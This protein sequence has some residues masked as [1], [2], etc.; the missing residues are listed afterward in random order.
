MI[1]PLRSRRT[2]CCALTSFVLISAC[3]DQGGTVD[4]ARTT[5]AAPLATAGVQFDRVTTLTTRHAVERVAGLGDVNGDGYDDVGLGQSRYAPADDSFADLGRVSILFG[6]ASGIT[7]A[8]AQHVDGTVRGERR[9]RFVRAGDVNGDGY[10]DVLI[11]G[12]MDNLQDTGTA[13]HLGGP[14]GLGATP[15]W[16]LPRRPVYARAQGNVGDVNGDGRSDV[17]FQISEYVGDAWRKQLGVYAG[18]ATGL[19]PTPI[20]HV[21]VPTELPIDAAAGVGD[22][23][24]D[25][26][27]DVSLGSAFCDWARG[28]ELAVY[29]GAASG[30]STSAGWTAQV[31]TCTSATH[32]LVAAGD[33]NGDG[34]ADITSSTGGRTDIT[35]AALGFFGGASPIRQPFWNVSFPENDADGTDISGAGDTNGDGYADV[36]LGRDYHFNPSNGKDAELPPRGL[37]SVYHGASGGLPET[38]SWWAYDDTQNGGLF[39]SSTAGAGD[40]N[41]D[42][43]ADLVVSDPVVRRTHVFYA[44]ET[45][46]PTGRVLWSLQAYESGT[47]TPVEAGT[48]TRSASSFDVGCTALG[49]QGRTFVGLELE[50]KREADPYDGTN[51]LRPSSW[52]DTGT[53]GASLRV[54]VRDLDGN[55]AYKYRARLVYRADTVALTR[56]TRW[57]DG[58]RLIT[59]CASGAPPLDAAGTCEEPEP[60]D[61]GTDA[62]LVDADADAGDAH[63]VTADAG[64]A[65]DASGARDVAEPIDSS[66]TADAAPNSDARA[67]AWDGSDAAVVNPSG[68]GAG[69]DGCACR[70]S[71][72]GQPRSSRALLLLGAGA[73]LGVARRRP[74][75]R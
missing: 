28:D 19:T 23:N 38:H 44:A 13:L 62:P 57:F 1:H 73:I 41:G 55:T 66:P 64:G 7:P 4:S 17:L 50:V 46:E 75:R 48:R 20:W 15:V 52:R 32:E 10:A 11:E 69:D 35:G 56:H 37:A 71:R 25:G 33:V 65:S 21:D 30:L 5:R 70:V 3:G 36:V 39:G 29:F 53:T 60:R 67:D 6:S 22:F 12:V 14:D 45:A 63:E 43:H 40:L 24:G 59:S 26:H 2:L 27:P 68:G 54:A 58:G 18:T 16:H 9:A 34:F 51:L 61:G 74:R 47:E 42:G 31:S 72:S 8:N 49:T